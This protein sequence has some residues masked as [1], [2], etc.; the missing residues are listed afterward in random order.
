VARLES[1]LAELHYIDTSRFESRTVRPA[2]SDVAIIRYDL[3]WV[4]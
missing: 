3:V 2:K 1:D 4:S